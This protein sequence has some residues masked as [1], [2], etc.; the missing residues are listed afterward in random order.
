M[1]V[2]RGHVQIAEELVKLLLMV[3]YYLMLRLY[4]ICI[5]K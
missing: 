3:L 5:K 1:K 4:A 2:L